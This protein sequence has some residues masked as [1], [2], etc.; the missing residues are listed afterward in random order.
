MPSTESNFDCQKCGIPFGSK[1][2]LE[3]H[4]KQEHGK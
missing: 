3:L 1:R 4:L 2:E